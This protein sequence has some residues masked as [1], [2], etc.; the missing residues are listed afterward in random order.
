M[1][2]ADAMPIEIDVTENAVFKWGEEVGE[3][4]G[5]SLGEAR[6]EAML[7]TKFLERRFGPLQESVRT[8]I[9][10]ADVDTIDRWADRLDLAASLEAIFTDLPP[11]R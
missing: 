8:R 3:A 1:Q 2:E 7:L 10:A 9:Y 4:K 5:I 11:G 6:G